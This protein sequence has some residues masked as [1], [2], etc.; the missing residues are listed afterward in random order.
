MVVL[1]KQCAANDRS[2]QR[3]AICGVT[4]R[5][6]G[7]KK[8]GKWTAERRT[9]PMVRPPRARSNPPTWCTMGTVGPAS[10][11][12]DFSRSKRGGR[13][14]GSAIPRWRINKRETLYKTSPPE[15]V[16]DSPSSRPGAISTFPPPLPARSP[17]ILSPHRAIVPLQRSPTDIPNIAGTWALRRNPAQYFSSFECSR[18]RANRA[19]RNASDA[20]GR[21]SRLDSTSTPMSSMYA[22]HP[23]SDLNS[24]L[25]LFE[26]FC[27]DRVNNLSLVYKSY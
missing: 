5:Q 8:R 21:D 1:A 14:K 2:S 17:A 9:A 3:P 24:L 10:A 23:Q 18:L 26:E 6:R 16:R 22:S 11:R 25:R 19:T 15:V 4:T 27:V 20:V 13:K 12:R 7:K